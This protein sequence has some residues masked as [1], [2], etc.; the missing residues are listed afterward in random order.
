MKAFEKIIGYDNVKFELFRI[1]DAL[2]NPDKYKRL[3]VITPRGVLLY[4]VPGVGKTIMA[5]CLIE[6]SSRKTF[7]IRKNRTTGDFID[8]IRETFEKAGT[9]SPSIVFLDDL[10]KFANEDQMHTDA[11]EYVAVQACIDES[12]RHDVFILATVNNKNQLPDSLLRPGRFDKCIKMNPPEGEEASKIIDFFLKQKKVV[13]NIDIRE[14]AKLIDGRSC[15]ELEAVINEAGIYAAYTGKNI[16]EQEDIIK[17]CMRMIFNAPESVSEI[18][19]DVNNSIAIHEAG[20]AVMA[21]ILNPGSVNLVSICKH[22]GETRGICSFSERKG[23]LFSK[24]L[25]EHRIM[26]SLGGKAATEI[27]LG[28]ADVGCSKDLQKAYD[29]A[30]NF[31]SDCCAYGFDCIGNK[32]NQMPSEYVL[33]N[34]ARMVTEEINRCYHETKK[35]L[36]ENRK[37]LECF[38]EELIAKKTLTY[39]D[40]C[41]M[42]EN[43]G[44][45]TPHRFSPNNRLSLP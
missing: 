8:H 2:K 43:N 29:L 41:R 30:E 17:A 25:M 27:I 33:G 12:V 35:L 9:E 1:C 32:S 40:I 37:M 36:I 14:I 21:E 4:G 5:E 26:Q 6:E 13:D 15:A 11:E 19:D 23:Y 38:I 3:G 31:I 28:V 18:D 42:K 44:A 10:D 7:R 45:K 16:I 20:H 22:S 39:N 24:K 34:I